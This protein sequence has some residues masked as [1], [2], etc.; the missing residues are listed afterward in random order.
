MFKLIG[1]IIGLINGGFWGAL[2]GVFVGHIIDSFSRIKVTATHQRTTSH[3]FT[4]TLLILTAEV[5]KAD[6]K[7]LKSEL[8]YIKNFFVQRQCVFDK[9]FEF[10]R[11]HKFMDMFDRRFFVFAG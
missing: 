7:L 1:G 3:D 9:S 11:S 6:D 8:Y 10:F 2:I 4:H 5:M